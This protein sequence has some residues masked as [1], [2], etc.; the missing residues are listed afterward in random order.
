MWKLCQAV[1][2]SILFFYNHRQ[3]LMHASV[4]KWAMSIWGFEVVLIPSLIALFKFYCI[5]ADPKLEIAWLI[6][7]FYKNKSYLIHGVA[8]YTGLN[9]PTGSILFTS[10]WKVS[11]RL[12][13]N[14]VAG[15]VALVVHQDQAVCDVGDL[16]ICQSPQRHLGNTSKSVPYW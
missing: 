13:R 1:A 14:W 15:S 16:G 2:A 6:F 4:I 7:A 12:T 10:C 5:Q 11:I 3:S 8:S 9:T